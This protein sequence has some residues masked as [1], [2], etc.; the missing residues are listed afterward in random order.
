LP[1]VNSRWYDEAMKCL[2]RWPI[3]LISFA[4]V[5]STVALAQDDCRCWTPSAEQIAVLEAKI[6]DHRALTGEGLDLYA[7]YYKGVVTGNQRKFI[8]AK[9]VPIGG[10]EVPGIHVVTGEMPTLREQGCIARLDTTGVVQPELYCA[11]RGA[12]TPSETQIAKLEDALRR[13]GNALDYTRYARHYA[14]VMEGNRRIIIGQLLEWRDDGL[15]SF[16]KPGI[17]VTSEVEIPW[18]ADGLCFVVNVRYDLAS[19]ELQSRC[20]GR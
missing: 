12:W 16:K 7:R 9:F 4:A 18:A 13:D 15:G 2:A 10:S 5:V 11:R 1:L 6:R 3:V 17:Y 19:K 8:S 14:G 20:G